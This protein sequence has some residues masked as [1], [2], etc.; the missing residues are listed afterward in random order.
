V[1]INNYF[2]G[3]T[4]FPWETG[5]YLRAGAGLSN[6]V[7]TVGSQTESSH[8]LGLVLGAGY[9]FRIIDGHH[10]SITYTQ[11]WQSYGGSSTTKPDSSQFG[12]VYLGYMYR[13]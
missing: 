4:H 2:A 10:L 7:T 3:V 12:G 9:A 8:G 11:T 5:L 13:S 1:Q 6:F